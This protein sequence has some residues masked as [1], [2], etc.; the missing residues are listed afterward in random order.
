MSEVTKLQDIAAQVKRSQDLLSVKNIEKG[1]GELTNA[2]ENLISM[3][4]AIKDPAIKKL[5]RV[6]LVKTERA[7]AFYS[8]WATALEA[9]ERGGP[10][11][12]GAK[13]EPQHEEVFA[14]VQGC[15]DLLQNIINARGHERE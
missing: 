12:E 4:D 5:F 13:P 1:L 6:L 10:V 9:E 7:V 14:E 15:R 3:E 8:S 2:Q 11:A